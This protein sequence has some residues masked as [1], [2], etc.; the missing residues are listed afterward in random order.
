[1]NNIRFYF[2]ATNPF[3]FTNFSGYSPE[4]VGNDNAN[5]LGRAGIELDAYP[6]NKTILFGLNISL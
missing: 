1:L 3:V 4:I 5:P 2:T 6:T